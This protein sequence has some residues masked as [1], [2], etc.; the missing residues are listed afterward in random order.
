MPITKELNNIWKLEAVGFLIWMGLPG[1]FAK[2]IKH[3][4]RLASR[5]P[6]FLEDVNDIQRDFQY[7]DL[8]SIE[9]SL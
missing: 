1:I 7:A 3:Q 5:D 6:L 4:L 8:E 2:E 9:K